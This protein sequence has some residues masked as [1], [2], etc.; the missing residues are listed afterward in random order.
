MKLPVDNIKVAQISDFYLQ[1]Y[2]GVSC[3]LNEHVKHLSK[4]KVSVVIITYGHSNRII[5][6]NSYCKIY[7]LKGNPN[8]K[9][10]FSLSIPSKS[11]I[12][13][14][15]VGEKITCLNIHLLTPLSLIALKAAKELGIRTIY[16]THG[17]AENYVSNIPYMNN[18]LGRAIINRLM[19]FIFN[20]VDKIVCTSDNLRTLFYNNKTKKKLIVIP[21][22][23]DLDLFKSHS[24]APSDK[25]IL[26][27]GRLSVEKNI[28]LLIHAFK[29]VLS[30]YPQAKLKIV[31]D[32]PFRL[33]LENLV[34]SLNLSNNVF[35][36]GYIPHNIISQEYE[37]SEI[38]VLPST[39]EPFGLVLLEAMAIEKPIVV[40]DAI[41]SQSILREYN[42]RFYFRNDDLE[43]FTNKIIKALLVKHKGNGKQI[44]SKYFSLNKNIKQWVQLYKN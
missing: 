10:L 25:S 8:Y 16:T 26:Y 43:D 13:K 41:T 42:L 30:F 11:K 19:Q 39:C 2:G 21:N 32:G 12:K 18:A 5:V 35:F 28:P 40:S 17:L 4:N 23:I 14:I 29:K 34:L 36:K 44:V 38:F 9:N 27:V 37:K 15:L 1:D 24:T 6:K 33:K 22:S 20:R 31:G 3:F 7:A